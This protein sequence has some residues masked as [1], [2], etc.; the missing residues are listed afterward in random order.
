MGVDVALEPSTRERSDA[1]RSG[2]VRPFAFAGD[3]VLADGA[4]ASR[5]GTGLADR[6]RWDGDVETL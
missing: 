1:N 2:R 5:A 3:R 4:D 6:V